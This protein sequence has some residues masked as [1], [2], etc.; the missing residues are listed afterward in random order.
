MKP[1]PATVEPHPDAD[2]GRPFSDLR[3]TGLLWL[4]N[5]VVLHPRGYALALIYADRENPCAEGGDVLGW[6][7]VGD[8]TEP[9]TMGDPPADAI[10]AGAKTEDELF[11]AIKALLP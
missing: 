9:W 1:Q 2:N 10:A 11:A 7:I 5:R 6:M 3:D 4:I 8:G